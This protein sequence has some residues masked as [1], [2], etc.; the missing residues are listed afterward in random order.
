MTNWPGCESNISMYRR[1][2]GRRQ[3]KRDEG[4]LKIIDLRFRIDRQAGT[5][6]PRAIASQGRSII[7]PFRKRYKPFTNVI[8][9]RTRP[10]LFSPRHRENQRRGGFVKKSL[11]CTLDRGD[12][13]SSRSIHG[14]YQLLICALIVLTI[15]PRDI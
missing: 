11:W 13:I 2:V 7:F 12:S 1:P 10:T 4:T 8:G 9:P 5:E 15:L 14:K 3:R 6:H